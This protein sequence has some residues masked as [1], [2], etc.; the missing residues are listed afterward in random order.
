MPLRSKSKAHS[1]HRR[2]DY[3]QAPWLGLIYLG[4]VF[5]PLVFRRGNVTTPLL[6]SLLACALFVPLWFRFLRGCSSQREKWVQIGVVA[7]LGYA[8]IPLNSG[9]NTFVVY[10]MTMAAAVLPWRT[11]LWVAGSAWGLMTLQF[12]WVRTDTRTA[13]G[14]SLAIAVIGGMACANILLGRA[15]DRQHAVLL[16]SQDEV[17]RLAALAE[18]ERIGRD[19]H[20]VLGHT[21]SLVVLKT[22]L[23]RRLLLHDLPAAER[24]LTELE[25]AARDALDQVREAVSGVRTTGLVAE[26]AAARLALLSAD[27]QLDTKI[28]SVTLPTTIDRA[29]A[30]VLREAVTNVIRHAKAQHVDVR[31]HAS[32]ARGETE[33]H[34]QIADNGVGGAA[35]KPGHT[36]LPGFAER[37]NALG[38]YWEL[39]SPPGRG[40]HLHFAVKAAVGKSSEV[41]T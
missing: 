9:G 23:T 21:L 7:L 28:P 33:W 12:L 20:D 15:R 19:L 27:I 25:Q 39:N 13:L 40:T 32:V 6:A 8:L 24:Q 17:R 4:F 31:L 34:L 1:D 5:L 30:F 3:Q 36:G 10:T 18:R 22:Q 29:L 41:S 26:L 2:A 37:M 11:A 35:V 14:M 38:G 16:L